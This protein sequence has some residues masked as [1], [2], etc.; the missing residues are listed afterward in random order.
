MIQNDEELEVTQERI[1]YFVKLLK[2]IR[3]ASRPEEYP[4]VSGGYRAEIKKMQDE[5]LEYLS[6]PEAQTAA[7]AG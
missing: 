3:M 1:A 2:G 7:K 4:L 5:V 6:K